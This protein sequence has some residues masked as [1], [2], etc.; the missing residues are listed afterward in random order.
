MSRQTFRVSLALTVSGFLC[1]PATAQDF[2]SEHPTYAH[3]VPRGTLL[4]L[5]LAIAA[6]SPTERSNCRQPNLAKVRLLRNT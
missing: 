5:A 4:A 1:L 3:Y 2:L 6:Y